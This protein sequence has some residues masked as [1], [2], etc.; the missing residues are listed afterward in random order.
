[1]IN[2]GIYDLTQKKSLPYY[3]NATK[4]EGDLA[5][6]KEFILKCKAG[7]DV[8]VVS[9][10]G[11]VT[12]GE[13]A[14]SLDKAYPSLIGQWISSR[15]GIKVNAVNAGCNG[16]GSVIGV[17]RVERD[18]LRHNPDLVVVEF[19]VNDGD[20]DL[21]LEAYESLMLRLLTAESRPAVIHFA[22][23]GRD[24]RSSERIHRVV[25]EHYNVPL[26]SLIPFMDW[27]KDTAPYFKDGVHPID[28]GFEVI[29]NLI[30]MKLADVEAN[31]D[32]I[33][34]EP[35]PLPEK[36]TN[37]GM[38]DCKAIDVKDIPDLDFGDWFVDGFDTVCTT[39]G[40]KPL[41]IK[42]DCSYILIKYEQNNSLNAK[43]KIVI[44][45]KEEEAK[46]ICNNGFY[47]NIVASFCQEKEPACHEVKIYM[48]EGDRFKMST[49]YLSNF[50]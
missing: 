10:G 8:T 47:Y 34:D 45:G 3:P 30:T 24:K 7:K 37:A 39:P 20:N 21:D 1:M 14:T 9:I 48:T 19:S 28:L 46:V 18:V 26:I 12:Q 11:S 44:D 29:K 40:G 42:A 49:A 41:V 31:L 5:R 27:E 36:M 16:T 22:M 6:L 43:I 23:C 38:V 2:T 15:F 50:I 13:S 33:N 35:L 32:L 25:C 4:V 17:E